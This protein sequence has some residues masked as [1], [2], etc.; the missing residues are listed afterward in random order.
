MCGITGVAALRE[1]A[2]LPR[3]RFDAMCSS[4]LHRGPDAEGRVVFERVFLGMRRLAVIDPEGGDQPIFNEDRSVAV[5]FNG[6][7][8][9]Y[10]ELR[11]SL[12][13]RHHRFVTRSDTE[14]IVHA[15]EEY[16]TDF[17]TRLNGMFAIALY[18]LRRRRVV[19]ARDHLGVKPLYFAICKDLLVWG[20][21]IKA[22][23]ASGAAARTLDPS[24]LAEF[25]AWEYVPGPRTLFDDVRKLEPAHLLIAD[26]PT[27]RIDIQRYWDIPDRPAEDFRSAD[28]WAELVEAQVRRSVAG[29]LVSDVPLG[30]FLSGGVDSSLVVS[31]MG[32]SRTFS[33]GFTDDSYDESDYARQVAA[34]L[35]VAHEAATIRPVVVDLFDHLMQFMDDPIGDVSIF[36]TFLLS[37]LA[38]RHVTVSLSGDGGDELF[39]G[40]DTYLAQARAR[41]LDSIAAPVRRQVSAAIHALTRPQD[42]KKGV[43]NKVRRFAEGVSH[44]ARLGHARWRLFASDHML[45]DLLHGDLVPLIDDPDRHIRSLFQRASNMDPINRGLYVDTRSYLVDNCL[46]KVDRMS[47]A[48]S[49]EVRVPLLDRELTELA[50]RIPGRFK[51]D[52]RKTKVLLKSIAA[53][54]V[55]RNCVYRQKE[56][57]SIPMKQ[58]LG[59]QFRPIMEELLSEKRLR[60]Q[61]LFRP[62]TISRLKKQ[63]LDGHANHSHTLWCLMVFQRWHDLWL[64]G[65]DHA[66]GTAHPGISA[67]AAPD[68]S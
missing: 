3:D 63:H 22:I 46:T 62:E 27:G 2:R 43:V 38:R 56:G 4:L 20:S 21:E 7:I 11:R 36:P 6:E 39:G 19:L 53:K 17:P 30:A 35:G 28:E 8:Y 9:N 40:Y 29:Q 34:H 44:D 51:V 45:R 59:T 47:M 67:A 60:E 18:D 48:V 68:A 50:F 1:R 32:E 61:G 25:L 31:A 42:Q 65:D 10:R 13:A 33:I 15:Y 12:E 54:S 16:G 49:L 24:A 58:W 64:R 5:V 52:G 57:F 55:P 23:L 66:E 14:V 26:L 37:R 41:P